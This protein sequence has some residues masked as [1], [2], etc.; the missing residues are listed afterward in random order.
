MVKSM[1]YRI[2]RKQ[3]ARKRERELRTDAGVPEYNLTKENG[4]SFQEPSTQARSPSILYKGNST[5]RWRYVSVI[6]TQG[7][8]ERKKNGTQNSAR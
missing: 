4:C 7:H 2:A 6:P 5:R 8:I 3:K 1:S